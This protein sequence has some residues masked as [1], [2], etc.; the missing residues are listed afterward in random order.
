MLVTLLSHPSVCIYI[1]LI[2]D[3]VMVLSPLMTSILHAHPN[4]FLTLDKLLY[5]LIRIFLKNNIFDKTILV[6]STTFNGHMQPS[7]MESSQI[8]LWPSVLFHLS[9]VLWVKLI[10]SLLH[11]F[12]NRYINEAFLVLVLKFFQFLTSFNLGVLSDRNGA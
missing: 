6:I 10:G 12:K 3:N 8:F 11:A 4:L 5:N 9:W 2:M 7:S 1:Y